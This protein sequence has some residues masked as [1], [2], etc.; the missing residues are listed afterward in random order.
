[1]KPRRPTIKDSTR[2]VHGKRRAEHV[3]AKAA[4]RRAAKQA[5]LAAQMADRKKDFSEP[6]A[7]SPKQT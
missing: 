3:A 5:K 2:N 4:R 6:A 1:M 7:D